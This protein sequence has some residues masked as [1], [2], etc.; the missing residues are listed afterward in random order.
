MTK[1]AIVSLLLGALVALSPGSAIGHGGNSKFRSEFRSI[2]PPARGITVDVLNY[3]DRLLLVNRTGETVSIAGY[4]REPYARLRADGSV[5]V[6]RRSPTH[7][8]N[9]ER[10]GGRLEGAAAVAAGQSHRALRVA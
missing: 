1:R 9:E 6:N 10:Y 7:Y 4:E 5:E 8:L 3:D 2:Q